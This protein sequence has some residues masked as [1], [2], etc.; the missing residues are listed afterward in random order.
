V[1]LGVFLLTKSTAR[2]GPS[3]A[4]LAAAEKMRLVYAT[5]EDEA[6]PSRRT[7][8]DTIKALRMEEEEEEEAEQEEAAKQTGEQATGC[9]NSGRAE[10]WPALQRTA[11]GC[12]ATAACFA[13]RGVA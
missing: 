1:F 9:F 3:A 10:L 4:E 6:V 2:S 12:T 7:T 8:F 5:F 11:R 13:V